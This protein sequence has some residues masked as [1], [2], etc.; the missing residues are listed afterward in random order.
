M[1]RREFILGS[2]A[3]ALSARG[4]FAAEEEKTTDG[5]FAEVSWATRERKDLPVLPAGAKSAEHFAATCVGCGLCT[6]V[7]P[8]KC[9]RPSTDARRFGRVELDFRHGWCK[10][11]CVKCSEVCPAGAIHHIGFAEKRT[12]H[13][14]YAA[15]RKDLCLRVA[16]DVQCHACE[17]HC[18]TKAITLIDGVPVVNREKC[19]GC[20]ACEHYCPARPLTAMHVV[21]YEVQRAV[22]PMS[23]ADLVAEM[24][25]LI[26]GGKAY[27]I[28]RGGVIV[29][30]GEGRG[31]KPMLELLEKNAAALQDAIVMDKVC[32]RAS[33][34][35]C[36]VGKARKVYSP[37]MGADAK[38]LLEKHGIV[39]SAKDVVPKILNHEHTG[40]CPMDAA[41]AEMTDPAAIV[42]TLR[43]M[44]K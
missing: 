27:V 25:T 1:N 16:E 39:A 23:E 19:I 43:N 7:C 6:A 17:K 3:A 26:E 28:A 12:T 4:S 44:L 5:G 14:G 36:I 32:G 2:S 8:S 42:E 20:G 29:V 38:A 40:G 41:T 9:L 11:T 33:A 13:V 31:V 34:A 35:I 22:R 21:G 18:P 37:V 24:R 10:P 30:S 15:W